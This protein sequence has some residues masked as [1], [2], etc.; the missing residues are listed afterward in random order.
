[1]LEDLTADDMLTESQRKTAIF[2]RFTVPEN[3][4]MQ[5]ALK[6]LKISTITEN[7]NRSGRT[8]ELDRVLEPEIII[9][10]YLCH[11]FS[12][13][14]IEKFMTNIIEIQRYCNTRDYDLVCNVFN[15]NAEL[16]QHA[17][18][19]RLVSMKLCSDAY[20]RRCILKIIEMQIENDAEDSEI[21]ETLKF[22]VIDGKIRNRSR[23]PSEVNE[24]MLKFLE[25]KKYQFTLPI[26]YASSME[27]PDSARFVMFSTLPDYKEF[28]YIN[29]KVIED[30]SYEIRSML[31]RILG[32]D[33]ADLD[34]E[35]LAV[36]L[37]KQFI[38]I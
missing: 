38:N 24:L 21:I 25:E 10:D 8:E 12:T 23:I 31:L 35:R 15:S 26:F 1:M 5:H 2:N 11:D 30:T 17:R 13:E 19:V 18:A 22:L 29:A 16:I 6:E 27:I 36:F 9:E 32:E 37:L 34:V 20:M 4:L 28:L 14:N 3:P 7:E 33:D